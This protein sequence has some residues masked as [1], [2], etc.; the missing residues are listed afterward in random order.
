MN[1]NP[2]TRSCVS[3]SKDKQ[4]ENCASDMK[5]FIYE[6]SQKIPMLQE[7]RHAHKKIKLKQ[8][9]P[10]VQTEMC[11]SETFYVEEAKEGDAGDE[12]ELFNYSGS[13]E[14]GDVEVKAEREGSSEE[15]EEKVSIVKGRNDGGFAK[16]L[17]REY[18][19]LKGKL[20]AY[21]DAIKFEELMKI[22]AQV[23]NRNMKVETMKND[24]ERY[25]G[26][27]I[28]DAEMARKYAKLFEKWISVEIKLKNCYD[29]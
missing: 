10:V 19:E 29:N 17:Q 28:K 1:S 15:D 26:E 11:V 25:I 7:S 4:N 22:Y 27:H 6:L 3:A 9:Y 20:M 23:G 24:I 14:E 18:N 12:G 21:S 16:E 2:K 5:H 8:Q 13:E